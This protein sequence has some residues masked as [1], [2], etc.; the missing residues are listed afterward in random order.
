MSTIIKAGQSPRGSARLATIDLADHLAET[1]AILAGAREEARAIVTA[2]RKEAAAL[3]AAARERG[4]EEG[5]VEGRSAGLEAGRAE[6]LADARERYDGEL[7]ALQGAFEAAVLKVEAARQDLLIAARRDLL[8]FAVALARRVAKRVATLDCQCAA[9]NLEEAL[10]LV[11]A[12]SDAIVKVNPHELQSIETFAPDLVRR[13]G[14]CGHLSI[15][16]DAE[17]EPGGCVLLTPKTRVDARI[18][19][20]MDEITTLLLGSGP[21]ELSPEA[22]PLAT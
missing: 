7:G 6:G 17:V 16:A 2:A 4:Y 11:G 12:A 19:T 5:R 10:G 9:A 14:G 18:E 3:I 21:P 1:Q 15:V 20:Q 8:E 22:E 13:V